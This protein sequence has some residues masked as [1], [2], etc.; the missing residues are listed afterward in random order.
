MSISN[1]GSA[2]T[3]AAGTWTYF[4]EEVTAPATASRYRLAARLGGT[5]AASDVYYVWAMRLTRPFADVTG[6]R[7]GDS[8]NRANS[9][10]SLG[11]TDRETVQAW[12]QNSGTWGINGNAGYIS[13]AGASIATVAG[14]ADFDYLSVEVPTWAS[15][16]AE[17]VFRFTDTSNYLRFGGTVGGTATFVITNGGVATLTLVADSVLGL[18]A[19]GQKLSVRCNGSVTECFINDRLVICTADIAHQSA[20]RV[21]MRLTTTAPRMDNFMFD[22]AQSPQYMQVTRG[23]NDLAAPHDAGAEIRLWEPPYRGL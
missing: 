23:V 12:V 11:S 2:Q 21:G 10:T 9:T 16:T 15:G 19:A 1:S 6:N 17:L 20:T 3:I 7:S 13:A 8:F 4:E 22:A 5:P 18:L 14:S